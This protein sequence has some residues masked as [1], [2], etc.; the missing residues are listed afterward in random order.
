MS[1]G[2]PVISVE[3]KCRRAASEPP[4][5]VIT[6]DR[7][8]D[9]RG[10]RHGVDRMA[11][12]GHRVASPTL[13]ICSLPARDIYTTRTREQDASCH[14]QPELHGVASRTSQVVWTASENAIKS[15]GVCSVIRPAAE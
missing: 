4:R 9:D 10:Q 7:W 1:V 11:D 14:V 3:T 2:R 8:S 12:H 13:N 5:P 6:D 15:T